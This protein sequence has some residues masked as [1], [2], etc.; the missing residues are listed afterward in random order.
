MGVP[1]RE[2]VGQVS[3]SIDPP[4]VIPH[5]SAKKIETSE[6]LKVKLDQSHTTP[7]A[8]ITTPLLVRYILLDLEM[9]I[10]KSKHKVWI[11][12]A[13]CKCWKTFE[14]CVSITERI[15]RP[16]RKWV[17]YRLLKRQIGGGLKEI[18][19]CVDF[20]A[21][22]KKDIEDFKLLVLKIKLSGNSTT[23]VALIL[24]CHLCDKAQLTS[25]AKLV[26]Y[27]LVSHI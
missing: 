18:L 14:K 21:G 19:Y 5:N 12:Y 9:R 10:K 2:E 25:G 15:P 6:R 26:P 4:V 16:F 23:H 27:G 17:K 7:S 1:V 3:L 13:Q 22:L 11:I 8:L 24:F 20:K